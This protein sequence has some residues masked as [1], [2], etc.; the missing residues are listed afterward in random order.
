M[1]PLFTA[2]C[3]AALTDSMVDVIDDEVTRLVARGSVG[4]KPR[5]GTMMTL[6]AAAG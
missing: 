2:G 1:P 5:H 6:D 4:L 3:L